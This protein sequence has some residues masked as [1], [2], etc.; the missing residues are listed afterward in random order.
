MTIY[1]GSLQ[2]RPIFKSLCCAFG[3]ACKENGYPVKY[4]FSSE[5]AWLIPKE[6]KANTIFVGSSKN[7]SSILK[8]T[9]DNRNK[10][11]IR[12]AFAREKPTH[13]YLHNFHLLNSFIAKTARN[14]GSFVTY[15][16]HEP[17]VQNRYKSVYGGFHQYWLYI[18]EHYQG[19]LLE[20]IDF[21]IVSSKFASKLFDIRYPSFNGTKLLIPLLFEDLGDSCL[22]TQTRKYITFV[23]PPLPVKGSD[24]FLEITRYSS[25][26]HPDLAFQMTA[27]LNPRDSRFL[28]E[29]NLRIR[30]TRGFTDA[31][32]GKLIQQS[33]AVLAPFKRATQSATVIDSYMYGT[34]VVSSNVGGLPEIVNHGETG[35]LVEVEADAAQWVEGINYVIRKFS[36]LSRNCRNYFVE[37]HSE[38]NWLRY[39]PKLRIKK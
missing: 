12:D 1:V 8:D 4:L 29:K 11:T 10:S 15:H 36:K 22:Q 25:E 34:P 27:R 17:Y 38:K 13:V 14:Y 21:A 16:V 5:Y 32:F 3:K 37:H 28:H 23:G 30:S 2:F 6:V 18:F 7:I 9:S 20:N 39:L 31:A 35:Y 33:L 19:K 26:H 24:K